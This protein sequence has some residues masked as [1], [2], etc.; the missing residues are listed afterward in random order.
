MA[1]IMF[2]VFNMALNDHRSRSVTETPLSYSQVPQKLQKFIKN[3]LGLDSVKEIEK[4]T[5]KDSV[6][7]EFGGEE[8]GIEYDVKVTEDGQLMESGREI[9]AEELPADV[10]NSLNKDF[11]E[12]IIKSVERK[13]MIYYE[14][15]GIY[16]GAN[17]KIKI[18]PNGRIHIP[19]LSNNYEVNEELD[20]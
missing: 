11:P 20:E 19:N 5:T 16:K 12:I 2:Y 3:T 14:I 17:Q 4:I 7:Y 1:F 13:H 8:R 9:V 18:H 6:A 15:E 10:L